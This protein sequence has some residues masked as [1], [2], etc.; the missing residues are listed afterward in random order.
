M[1]TENGCRA[2][3]GRQ[4]DGRRRLRHGAAPRRRRHHGQD[5]DDRARHLHAGQDA[6]SAQPRAH[7]RRLV[8]RLG[9]RGR[10]PA[11]CPLALGTQTVGSVIRPGAFCG[12]YG[13]KPTYGVIPRTGVLTQAPSL[14]TVGVYG[15]SVE[16]LALIA[17]VLQGHDERDPASLSRA[18]RV[19][20][21]PPPRTGRSPRCSRSSRRT[22]GR[23]PTRRRTRPSASS[24]RS[25]AARHGD[26]PRPPPSAAIAAARL[27]QKVEMA[28]QFGPLLDRAPDLLSDNL[29]QQLEEGR[30]VTGVEYI[31]ALNA[32]EGS[33]PPSRTSCSTTA[34]SSRRPRSGPLP[35]DWGPPATRSSAASGPISACR[36]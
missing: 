15:R 21:R 11:W 20:W 16:D 25:W 34:R 12:V 27:V 6:Q 8:L 10:P 1:P 28:V 7:A 19:C 30:R 35:R 32:R 3:K 22:P 4:P 9:R 5:G 18:A 36:R 23:M 14:D 33:T 31:A 13:F 29:R 2:H 17:D 26:L 24:S